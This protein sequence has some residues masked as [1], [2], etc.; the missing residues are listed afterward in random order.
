MSFPNLIK[1]SLGCGNLVPAP[2][3]TTSSETSVRALRTIAERGGSF[4]ICLAKILLNLGTKQARIWGRT[5]F[6]FDTSGHGRCN[7]SDWGGLLNCQGY[8]SVPATL[9]EYALNQ[10]QNQ[11]FYDISLVDGFNI[12]LSATPS[13]SNCK[14]IGCTSNINAICASQLKVTQGCKSACAGFNMPQYYCMGPYLNNCSPRN[15]SKFFKGQCPQVYSYAKDDAT[16]TFTCPS[17][18]NYNVIFSVNNIIS[19]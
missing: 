8:G 7:T 10:Y 16:S 19:H 6:S 3:H 4:R 2:S 5:G 13:N 17:G 14:K 11:D 18:A 12:P 9:F 15:Y 1:T